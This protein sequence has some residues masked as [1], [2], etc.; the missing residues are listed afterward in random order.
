MKKNF[1]IILNGKFIAFM[2]NLLSLLPY[3]IK[4]SQMTLKRLYNLSIFFYENIFVKKSK[5]K[6]LLLLEK[7]T[8]KHFLIHFSVL[9][10]AKFIDFVCGHAYIKKTHLIFEEKIIYENTTCLQAPSNRTRWGRVHTYR[11]CRFR[12]T[13]RTSLPIHVFNM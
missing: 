6:F 9:M 11:G 8:F 7:T 10:Q 4:K 3:F 2:M 12:H 1:V 5:I 13:Y